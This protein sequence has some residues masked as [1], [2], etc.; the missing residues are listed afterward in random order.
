MSKLAALFKITQG[1]WLT[2]LTIWLVLLT[3]LIVYPG[4]SEPFSFGRFV[5]FMFEVALLCLGVIWLP[6]P[7]V[8]RRW[9]RSP[10]FILLTA[11]LVVSAV[12]GLL[13]VNPT[14]SWWGTVNRATGEIFF[15]GLW[16]LISGLAIIVNG[17]RAG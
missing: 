5:T 2:D 13:G 11:W 8:K 7:D 12:A 17:W 16:L 14:R 6:R 9:W 4:I 10:I 1:N 15:V 3:P